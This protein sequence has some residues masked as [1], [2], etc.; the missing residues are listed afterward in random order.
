MYIGIQYNMI[1]YVG[2]S[3]KC[4]ILQGQIN[5]LCIK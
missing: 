3:E 4:I 2:V 5:F 1:Q